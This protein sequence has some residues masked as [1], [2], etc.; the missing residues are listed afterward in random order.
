VTSDLPAGD[1]HDDD[2]RQRAA[3]EDRTL[4][5]LVP[6]VATATLLVLVVA[7]LTAN[8]NAT[9]S[10][11]KPIYLAILI[12]S[13]TATVVF[14][15]NSRSLRLDVILAIASSL[16]LL[17]GI[18]TIERPQL[19]NFGYWEGFGSDAALA[20]L[21][22]LLLVGVTWPPRRLATPLRVV[23][24]S[25]VI[26]VCVFDA[27]GAIRTLD[28]MPA[29]NNNLNEINDILG[30]MAGKVPDSSFIPQYTALYGW[31]LEPL[32]GVL[33]PLSLVGATAIMLTGFGFVTVALAVWMAKRV[34]AD[35]GWILALAL[36]VPIT[37]VTSPVT[38]DISSIASLFQELGI[39]LFGGFLI[40]SVGLHDL[41]L[42]YR[43]T[44]RVR[45]L[46]VVG[47]VCGLIAWNSQDFG[48][49][50]M[51][52]YGLMVLVVPTPSTRLRALGSWLTG[53]AM[54]LALYPLFLLVIGSPLNLSFVG[55]FAKL[56][57]SGMGTA[58]I[59]VPGPVLVVVPI[60]IS[61]TAAGWAL[62]TARRRQGTSDDV[63]LDR[64]A[65]ALAFVGTWS[66]AGLAYYMNRGYAAGQLQTMLLP[67]GVCVACLA[68]IALHSTVVD[69]PRSTRRDR[70]A[71]SGLYGN[72]TLFPV[73]LFVC[74][75]FASALLAPDPILAST[76]LLHP[77]AG[78]GFTSYDLPQVTAAVNRARTY[79]A[80][81]TGSLSYLGESFNYVA[82][83]MHVP[84]SAVLFPYALSPASDR[85]VIQIECQY[86]DDHRSRW[87]VLSSN[88][89]AA[90]GTDVC[91]LYHT[92]RLRDLGYGQLQELK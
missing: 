30:P 76:E 17:V 37:Y 33:S 12:L 92:V 44:L 10:V 41:L 49:A 63:R 45:R 91:G 81:K 66:A 62:M 68:S 20:S 77:P 80:G 65:I 59:Q 19:L 79:T 73:G 89:V 2:P 87:L 84:S 32:K 31:L 1:D 54:G 14:V 25:V 71:W 50:A 56:A 8:N 60:L 83:A 18:W 82:L 35:K 42:L 78:G 22:L 11:N 53:L 3:F 75:C 58:P 34:L 36:V 52:A 39:R 24:S 23:L 7:T 51:A 40:A 74:L 72:V 15:R 38:G 47:A 67:C 16:G 69:K 28:Y 48:V 9:G 64:A 4:T 27:L 13:A 90:F 6:R 5:A 61:A 46:V 57:V 21:A 29:V 55:A 43:G 88:A 85:T 70:M 86:L 26:A